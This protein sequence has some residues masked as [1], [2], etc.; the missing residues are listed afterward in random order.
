MANHLKYN[1]LLND[2]KS[3]TWQGRDVFT[4][5]ERLHRYLIRKL[6]EEI[7]QLFAKPD[8]TDEA[9]KGQSEGSWK[10][11]WLTEEA[12]SFTQLSPEA[13]QEA[14]KGLAAQIER[15]REYTQKL[16]KSSD[17]EDQ[18]WGEL[19]NQ[20]LVIPDESHIFTENGQFTLVAWGFRLEKTFDLNQVLPLTEES[21]DPAPEERPTPLTSEPT[22]APAS[23]ENQSTETNDAIPESSPS[24]SPVTP[25]PSAQENEPVEQPPEKAN[26][27]EPLSTQAN[28][29]EPPQTP[30]DKGPQK[31]EPNSR[32]PNNKERNKK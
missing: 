26:T 1:Q 29:E 15:L 27:P 3:L 30:N 16:A 20:A 18:K 23:S 31:K 4:Y 19:I 25:E 2:Y 14:K 5:Y 28:P 24:P 7:A 10:A 9:L 12:Q 17:I 32:E 13:Q 11:T 8:I 22:P 6:G 21:T